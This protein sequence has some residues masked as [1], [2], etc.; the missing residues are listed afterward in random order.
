MDTII[1]NSVFPAYRTELV[2]YV[3]NCPV[4]L[5]PMYGFVLSSR[6]GPPVIYHNIQIS[7]KPINIL[8]SVAM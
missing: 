2:P 4:A 6:S 5:K 1:K 3:S 7:Q 8:A